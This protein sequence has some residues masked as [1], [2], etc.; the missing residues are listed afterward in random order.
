MRD[1]A[2]R[3]CRFVSISPL[4]S[5]LPEEADAEWLPVSPAPTPR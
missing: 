4:R 1:A 5:D 3:G 2:A